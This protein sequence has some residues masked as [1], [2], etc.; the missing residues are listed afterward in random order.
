MTSRAGHLRDSHRVV[1]CPASLRRAARVEDLKAIGRP[2]VQRNVGVAED[3]RIGLRE[4]AFHPLEAPGRRSGVM[5]D[6]DLRLLRPHEFGLR[7]R[8]PHVGVIDVAVDGDHPRPERLEITEHRQAHEVPRVDDEIGCPQPRDAR[9]RERSLSARE[10]GVRDDRDVHG[11]LRRSIPAPVAQGIERSPPEREVAG[12]N[13]AGRAHEIP[14]N[15][16]IL[17]RFA[18]F[19]GQRLNAFRA[20]GAIQGA[21]RRPDADPDPCG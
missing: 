19:T 12:S 16:C 11:K 3:D 9:V 5:N 20:R 8:R 10:V 13:P 18:C 4:A 14:A 17:R 15:P 2:L 21:I 1:R 7:E 6:P